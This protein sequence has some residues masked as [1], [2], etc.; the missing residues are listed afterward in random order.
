MLNVDTVCV[1]FIFRRMCGAYSYVV[2]V[3]SS[4]RA[5]QFY[6]ILCLLAVCLLHCLQL[7]E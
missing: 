2:D 3:F 5:K 7:C 1:Y 6:F 4:S